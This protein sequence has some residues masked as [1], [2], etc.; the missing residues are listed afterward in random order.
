[1]D[2]GLKAIILSALV[3]GAVQAA[4]SEIETWA[5]KLSKELSQRAAHSIRD[6]A[7]RERYYEEWSADLDEYPGPYSKLYRAFGFPVAALKINLEQTICETEDRVAR[8]VANTRRS[9]AGLAMGLSLIV[10]LFLQGRRRSKTVQRIRGAYSPRE[11][12]AIIEWNRLRRERQ[13]K[14]T[15]HEQIVREAVDIFREAEQTPPPA[16]SRDP[17]DEDPRVTITNGRRHLPPMD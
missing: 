1:M 7:A 12:R 5:P 6:P 16:P 17:Y 4:R 13:R 3:G 8:A 10:A 14:E 15:L 9:T 11:T 2:P